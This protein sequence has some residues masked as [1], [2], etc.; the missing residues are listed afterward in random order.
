MEELHKA[1]NDQGLTISTLPDKGR[2]IFTTRDF[3]PGEVI[4]SQSPFVAVPNVYEESPESKCEWCF[5]S[6][7][8]KACSAC[9]AV[10]YCSRECQKSDWKLH[11]AE[12]KSLSKVEK[13]RLKYLTPMIRLMVKP[14]Q[15]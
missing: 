6:S 5:S 9:H 2:C 10:W 3:S 1:L 15:A 7:N 4:I 11:R 12:C 13:E 14:Y 8:I